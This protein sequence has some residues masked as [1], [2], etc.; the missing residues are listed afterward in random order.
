MKPCPNCH[1]LCHDQARFCPSCGGNVQDAAASDADPFIDHLL[2]DRYLLKRLIGEGG[3]GRVYEAEQR[4]LEK[5]VAVKILHQHL[6]GDELSV[7][8]FVAEAREASRLNHPNIVS[9]LEFGETPYNVLF[10][11]MEYLRGRPLSEVIATEYPLAIVRIIQIFRQVLLA[12]E[13]AHQLGVVHRDLKPDNVFI[14]TL[15]DGSERVKVIDFGIAKR[16]DKAGTGLTSPGMVCG[17]PEYMSPEQVVGDPLDPRS[18]VYALGILLYELL[19][20]TPPFL[21]KSSAEV[22]LM[23]AEDEPT[24]PSVA[25]SELAI[26]ESLDAIVL[27]ALSKKREERISSAEEFRSVLD[28]WLQVS[29]KGLEGFEE[30]AGVSCPSCSFLLLS[31]APACPHCGFS[32]PGDRSAE[33][34]PSLAQSLGEGGARRSR[35]SQTIPAGVAAADAASAVTEVYWAQTPSAVESYVPLVGREQEL[36]RLLRGV[37]EGGSLRLVGPA[38]LGKTRLLDEAASSATSAGWT[39]RRLDARDDPYWPSPAWPFRKLAAEILGLDLSRE[40]TRESMLL[41]VKAAGLDRSAA[42]GLLALF[43]VPQPAQHRLDRPARKRE[44]MAALGELLAQAASRSPQALLIEDVDQMDAASQRMASFLQSLPPRRD[45][46]LVTTYGAPP[47]VSDSV[48]MILLRP[49]GREESVRLATLKRGGRA[50]EPDTFPLLDVAGG[51]PFFL[52]QLVRLV[53]QGGLPG[54]ISRRIELLDARMDRLP[55]HLRQALQRVAVYG[56]RAPQ[57]ALLE[58]FPQDEAELERDHVALE[59]LGLLTT[60]AGWVATSHL[61]VE[62][63]V[64]AGMPAEIRREAHQ[65]FL[66]RIPLDAR[67]AGTAVRHAV[68]SEDDQVAIEAL[69]LGAGLAWAMDDLQRAIQFLQLAL[70]K[71]RLRWGRGEL[72]MAGSTRV[73]AELSR[74]LA[75]ALALQGETGTAEAVLSEVQSLLDEDQPSLKAAV[76]MDQAAL[77]MKRGMVSHAEELLDRALKI[78]LRQEEASWLHLELL[79]RLAEVAV[80]QGNRELGLTFLSEGLGLTGELDEA[81]HDEGWRFQLALGA[82]NSAD[83]EVALAEPFFESA[84]LSAERAG[85][86]VGVL[87]AQRGHGE[88]LFAAGQEGPARDHF[89]EAFQCALRL[90]DRGGAAQLALRVG[91]LIERSGAPELAAEHYARAG[92]LAKAVGLQSLTAEASLRAAKALESGPKEAT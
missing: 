56:G 39:V 68:G 76:L 51:N 7:A 48:P 23:Q 21:A 70:Q 81:G 17:T 19:V 30:L 49:L 5:P 53:Q 15:V 12:L 87:E 27:W 62:E 57:S 77:A 84:R 67:T 89:T 46:L 88:L 8:R 41:A 58:A 52:D 59:Q 90:G 86:L 91:E 71:S 83:G 55:V 11:V 14:E 44:S 37:E 82:L 54:Q 22:M 20:G 78:A 31:N 29:A 42:P 2:A 66:T 45:L 79:Y 60:G 3:M 36:G 35:E 18:D 40:I 64:L 43:G 13:A 74:K 10:L 16:F 1:A 69:E 65:R 72:G 47:Q 25:T 33:G 80:R 26:P 73:T 24:A 63:A 75:R 9:V 92:D 6:L 50:L 38:G 85:S 32:L 4:P 28:S 34:R 61:I